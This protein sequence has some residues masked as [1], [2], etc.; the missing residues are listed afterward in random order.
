MA[1]LL[2]DQMQPYYLRKRV[3]TFG[4]ALECDLKVPKTA[5]IA[6]SLV[7]EGNQFFLLPGEE[8]LRVNGKNVSKKQQL[9][10]CDRLEWKEG[11]AVFLD[12]EIAS[13][14]TSDPNGALESLQILQNLAASITQGNFSKES[15]LRALVER[16]GAEEGFLLAA[17]EVTGAWQVLASEG[18]SESKKKT[19]FSST[20]LKEAIEKRTHVYVESIIGHPYA[21]HASVIAA[22]VFSVACLP[23]ILREEI[24][25][26]I[27]LFTK[28]P[29][30]SIQ[31]ERL[32]EIHLLA[33][34]AAMLLALDHKARPTKSAEEELQCHPESKMQLVKE[35]ILRLAPTPMNILITGETGTGKELIAKS[36][37]KNSPRKNAPFVAINC[38]AIPA[39]LLESILFGHERGSFTGA[40]KEQKGKFQQ[41]DGGTLF[42]DEI[43]DLSLDL[44]AKL[45]RVLQ[46][47]TVE[48]I[49]SIRPI[50]VDVRVVSA[51]HQDLEQL[52]RDGKFR[53]DL[54]FRIAGAKLA[55]ISLRDR[56]PDITYLAKYFLA[57]VAPEKTFSNMCLAEM[58]KYP[59]PGNVRELEQAVNRAAFMSSHAVIELP[60]LEL[61][62]FFAAD[63]SESMLA[64]FSDLSQAQA[65]F[66]RKLVEKVLHEVKGNRAQ[67][68]D[69]LG[70]SERTL[71]RIL[72]E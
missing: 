46:E 17:D 55:S 71:Y 25:G 36:L 67:A 52:I 4:S 72:S 16:A 18:A 49:G 33:T 15:A 20:I 10:N 57:Q 8:N 23:L 19:L 30:K 68:A 2:F 59:W 7:Q 47:K 60:D 44:Q 69:R 70:I 38:A 54:Y 39:S 53:Q 62:S 1:Q 65:E 43:G 64:Q 35:K 61:D 6:F 22:K 11:V 56:V 13:F 12:H 34:Q 58:E 41:A 51:T 50:R 27:F 26:A 40:V 24:V 9:K 48:P 14:S 28:T 29:G 42:L 37:H 5:A 21:E 31:R 3:Q 63:T 66:T 45:L 32:P